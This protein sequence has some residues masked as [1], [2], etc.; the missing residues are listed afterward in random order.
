MTNWVICAGETER[1]CINAYLI[2]SGAQCTVVYEADPWR[3]RAALKQRP[4]STGV[5]V[6]EGT[7]GPHAINIAAAIACDRTATEVVLVVQDASGSLRSRAKRAGISQVFTIDELMNAPA[8][9]PRKRTATDAQRRSV[10]CAQASLANDN[11]EAQEQNAKTQKLPKIPKVQRRE[12]VPV[13]TFVSGRGGVGKTTICATAGQIAASWGMHVALLDLDLAFGNL[14]SLCGL[15]H[16]SDLAGLIE[17]GKKTQSFDGS[18]G[19]RVSEYLEVYGPCR[20]PEYAELVQP[21]AAQL[22]A[23]LTQN[24]DLVLVDTTNN[25]GDAVAA[26]AQESDRLAIVTDERP[27]AI[28]A[29]A[30]CGGLAVRLG[31]VRTRIVRVMNGCDPKRRDEAFVA[32]ATSG[33]QCA[34]EIRVLDGELDAM[35]LLACGRVGDLVTGENPLALSMATGLAQMLHELGKL[36]PD[37]KA[38]LA[39]TGK[40]KNKRIFA[41]K[42]Q[43]S[44]L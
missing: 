24:H 8:T 44:S 19:A 37:E 17:D 30:R 41:R 4:L 18:Q 26:A 15:E 14:A 21:Y 22:I 9:R 39:L 38:Q 36:P 32:Q 11:R 34:R 5:I 6:G 2:K 42:Q 25:W 10:P 33:L 20:A 27:G 3:L 31:I 7:A 23:A 13:I 40:R 28:A 43:V 1:A 16:S 29:L 35:E 12:G